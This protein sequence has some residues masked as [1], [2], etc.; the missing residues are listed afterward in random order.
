M[1]LVVEGRAY[2]RV[3]KNGEPKNGSL[4]YYHPCYDRA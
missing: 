3:S 2:M 1:V 4:I